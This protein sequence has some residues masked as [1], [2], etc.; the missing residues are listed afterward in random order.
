MRVGVRAPEASLFVIHGATGDLSR[1]KLLPA[2]HH[3]SSGVEPGRRP[4]ILG[5]GRNG[6][7]TDESFRELAAEALREAGLDPDDT[8]AWCRDCLHYVRVAGPGDYR[9]L[10]A[11][12]EEVEAVHDLPGNRTFYLAL[13][14]GAF[15]SVIGGLGEAGLNDGPGWTRL[16]IEKPIGRDLASAVALNAEAH[17]HFDEGQIYRIDHYLGKETV[18]N[19]LVFRFAN[20]IF[21]SLW[22]RDRVE[23]VQ[24]TV[25]ESLGV[26]QRAG[27]YEKAGA[28]RDMVQN[29]LSQLVS[30]LAMEVP[31]AF[32]ATAVRY[33]KVK[34][35]RAIAPIHPE[36]LVLGQYGA[37]A[38]DGRPVAA[39]REEPGVDS[40]SETE[41]FAALKLKID[42][43]RWQGVPFYIRTGKRLPR[44]LTQIAVS[45]RRPPVSLFES[46]G[47]RETTPNVL[48]LTLQPD[49][50]F[51]LCVDVKE[52]G[53][54]FALRTLPLHFLYREA[55]GPIPDAYETLLLDVLTGD[56]TL[57]VHADE[58]EVSWG[59]YGPLLENRPGV[60]P[61]ESG[62]WG[63]AEADALLARNGHRW[64]GP[65]DSAALH[66]A[67][68]RGP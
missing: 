10:R 36:D 3:I 49:E 65:V 21:E 68:H 9:A 32:D 56:Q 16:V 24:I 29:H 67:A 55:F 53:E 39:Y 33:E 43:W 57:F 62:S 34:L 40:A 14:P 44:R 30:L 35:L 59:L 23:H 13:P 64:H 2:L 41:T 46:M 58:T 18:Q 15:A 27:Y 50:G 17:R 25:A 8:R 11:R 20:S 45:F 47:C 48:V 7:R 4:V 5:V 28:L 37:G 60:H 54:P 38:V 12:I 52:P 51:A 1:R 19:L 66:A 63:P 61:Y 42:T 26:E 22:N 31:I 6:D